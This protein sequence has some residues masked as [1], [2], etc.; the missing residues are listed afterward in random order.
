[1]SKD[2]IHTITICIVTMLRPETGRH[3]RAFIHRLVTVSGVNRVGNGDGLGMLMLC[4]MLLCVNFFVLLEI[5][6]SLEG[7]ITDLGIR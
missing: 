4:M 7:L 1:M 5:L 6:G 2:N 3:S